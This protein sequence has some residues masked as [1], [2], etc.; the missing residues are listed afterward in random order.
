M[1][2]L[3]YILEAEI[4]RQEDGLWRLEI[5]T[6]PGVWVDSPTIERALSEIQEIAAMTIDLYIEEGRPLPTGIVGVEELPARATVPVVIAEHHFTR[7]GPKNRAR[8][9]APTGRTRHQG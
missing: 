3:A 4:S 9:L 1:S 2:P 7:M 8:V 5:P 6:L